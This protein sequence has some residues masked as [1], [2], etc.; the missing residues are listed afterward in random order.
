MSA[1]AAARVAGTS[2]W[3]ARAAVLSVFDLGWIVPVERLDEAAAAELSDFLAASCERVVDAGGTPWWQLRD[4]E[5]A[6]TLRTTPRA[7][8]RAALD[9][10]TSRPDDLVQEARTR[11]VTDGPVRLEA[12]D[13]PGLSALHQLER[14]LGE[15]ALPDRAG[16][17]GGVPELRPRLAD[18]RR[19]VGAA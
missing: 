15:A 8:L 18:R 16:S 17:C 10:V 19:A 9:E 7:V 14:W 5:R 1:R 13:A 6:R 12:L 11:Y 2:E 3:L 4:T